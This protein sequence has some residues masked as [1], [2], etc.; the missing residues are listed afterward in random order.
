MAGYTPC[1]GDNTI[2]AQ[3]GKPPLLEISTFDW[4]KLEKSGSSHF[5]GWH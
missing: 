5:V 1:D 2:L 3:E 4:K